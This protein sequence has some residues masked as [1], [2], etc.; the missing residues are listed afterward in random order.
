VA[1]KRREQ[2]HIVLLAMIEVKGCRKTKVPIM[3]IEVSIVVWA[4]Q[5]GNLAT[6]LSS[7]WA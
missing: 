4:A 3:A 2:E 7:Y 5:I 6:L 1:L